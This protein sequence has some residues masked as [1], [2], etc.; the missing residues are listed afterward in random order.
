MGARCMFDWLVAFVGLVGL[1]ACSV[2]R[3]EVRKRKAA[4][5]LGFIGSLRLFRL[6]GSCS[7]L[8]SLSL[9]CLSWL[10]WLC[11][12]CCWR[13]FFP[14]DDCDKKKGQAVGLVLSSWVVGLCYAFA[15]CSR[16][17]CHTFSASS[18]FSPQLFQCWRLEP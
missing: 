4:H 18:G 13:L 6:F 2:R 15:N 12:L 11:W 8:A 17:S 16:A 5:F 9:L 7:L 3:L 10:C 1:Y 14:S